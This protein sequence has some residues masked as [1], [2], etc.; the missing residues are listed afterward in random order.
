M[1]KQSKLNF[2]KSMVLLAWI[3]IISAIAG[4]IW[5]AFFTSKYQTTNDAQIDQ[6]ITPVSS[7]VSGFIKEV[8]FE[9]NQAVKKGD[10]LLII[11]NEEYQNKALV[12]QADLE[13]ATS[14]I[15]VNEAEVQVKHGEISII[16]AQL[17]NANVQVWK[18]EQDFKR[19]ENLVAEKAAT[20]QQFERVKAE[21]ESSLAAKRAIEQQLNVAK[22]N[23]SQ[24]LTKIDPVKN[25][26]KSKKAQLNN[27]E[28]Y[29]RYTIVVAPYNG[30]VGNKYV[31][32]G[33]FIKEGQTLVNVVSAEKWVTA[34]F[35]ETQLNEINIGS[36]VYF[37]VDA[38]PGKKFYGTILSFSPASGSKFSLLPQNNATGNFIKIEQRIPTK[39]I[40]KA[41]QQTQKLLA[42]MN[43]M[44][45]A[46][47]N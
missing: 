20:Q 17:K 26:S 44:V 8:R 38:I 1:Q 16:E 11:D 37:T 24:A 15:R 12:A 9:E 13:T 14:S 2:H 46:T 19:F 42:G 22:A 25:V 30:F 40:L 18:T 29:V 10:T 43:V 23:Q 5:Y 47:K 36:E 39:I 27:A 28:L 6:Y 4:I 45:H 31:Q 21:Y 3:L 34:N 7:R 32:P 33:Q 41:N 35:R